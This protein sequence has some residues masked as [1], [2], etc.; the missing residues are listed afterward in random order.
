MLNPVPANM[1]QLEDLILLCYPSHQMLLVGYL[2]LVLHGFG[3]CMSPILLFS[4]FW[5]ERVELILYLS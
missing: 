3:R 1:G 2:V 5:L 4:S